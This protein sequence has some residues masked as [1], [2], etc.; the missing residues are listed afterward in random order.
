MNKACAKPV[1]LRLP[2]SLIS[3]CWHQ[4]N[5]VTSELEDHGSQKHVRLKLPERTDHVRFQSE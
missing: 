4:T 2:C 1:P 5:A 3:A